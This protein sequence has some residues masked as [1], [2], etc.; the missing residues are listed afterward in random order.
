M[1]VEMKIETNADPASVSVSG[2]LIFQHASQLNKL[3]KTLQIARRWLA[4][5]EK[6]SAG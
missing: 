1:R 6:K 4:E 5:N 2:T 3:I